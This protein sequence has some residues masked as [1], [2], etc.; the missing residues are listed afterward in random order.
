MSSYPAFLCVP[1]GELLHQN[2]LA[3]LSS[4][5]DSA[6]GSVSACL[7]EGA[8]DA[9]V[10]FSSSAGPRPVLVLWYLVCVAEAAVLW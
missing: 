9:P 2:A 8:A 4:Q 10:S 6:W 5:T 3:V 1:G 7:N